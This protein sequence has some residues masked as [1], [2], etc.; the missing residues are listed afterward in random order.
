[1]LVHSEHSSP[2]ALQAQGFQRATLGEIFSRCE[3]IVLAGGHTPKTHHMIRK[4]HFEAM[5]DEAVFVNIARGKMVNE[6]EMTAVAE[7]RNIQLALDVFEEEP[8]A[9][10]SPL[11]RNDRVILAP[12]RANAPREFEL[13]WQFLADELERF[14]QGQKPLTAMSIERARVMS[15]S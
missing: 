3:V 5:P 9:I 8:L 11:R 1:M 15:E 4:E 13:R 2:E 14:F 12:H 6:A 10:D 7:T